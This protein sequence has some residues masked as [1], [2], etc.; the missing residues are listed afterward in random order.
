MDF[1]TNLFPGVSPTIFNAVLVAVLIILGYPLLLM[2]V[3]ISKTEWYKALESRYGILFKVVT[4]AVF[5]AEY[6]DPA[7]RALYEEKA[8]TTGYPVKVLIVFDIVE[9]FASRYGFKVDLETEVLPMI[10]R[11]LGSDVTPPAMT[12]GAAEPET[13]VTE[14]DPV[15]LAAAKRFLKK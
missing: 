9:R 14:L 4:D 11:A 1:L 6:S 15:A 8:L 13:K 5:Q 10:M 2:L 3:R 7:T 12:P